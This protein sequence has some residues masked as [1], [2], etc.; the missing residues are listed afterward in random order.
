MRA[1]RARLPSGHPFWWD[2]EGLAAFERVDRDC[3]VGTGMKDKVIDWV[4]DVP[5]EGRDR[6]QDMMTPS[7]Y[8]D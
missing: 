8:G 6:D 3:G 4:N 2:F 5:V 7:S 1:L